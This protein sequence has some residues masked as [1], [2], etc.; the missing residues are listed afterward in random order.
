M[1]M[2]EAVVPAVGIAVNSLPGMLGKY[3]DANKC[4]VI[5][6]T[7]TYYDKTYYDKDA[8]DINKLLCIQ[9]DTWMTFAVHV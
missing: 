8:L 1:Y 5:V 9:H 2:Q 3:I 4:L 6:I 7:Y